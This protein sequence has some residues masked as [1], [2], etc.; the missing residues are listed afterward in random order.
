[1]V[2][3]VFEMFNAKYHKYNELITRV[4]KRRKER[5]VIIGNCL[6]VLVLVKFT[7]IMLKYSFFSHAPKL[8]VEH[9]E[10]TKGQNS[11]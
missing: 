8:M 4:V 10:N 1:M 6:I 7:H 11:N 5:W 9:D 3:T 2:N